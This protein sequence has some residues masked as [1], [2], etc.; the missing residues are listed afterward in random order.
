MRICEARGGSTL[1]IARADGRAALSI[2]SAPRSERPRP[3]AW[4]SSRCRYASART[5]CCPTCAGPARVSACVGISAGPSARSVCVCVVGSTVVGARER[6]HGS[7]AREAHLEHASERALAERLQ[8]AIVL[9]R[10]GRYEWR[11][12][13]GDDARRGEV[14]KSQRI[15][16]FVE[17]P[18]DMRVLAR[19]DPAQNGGD[20][21]H[22]GRRRPPSR[23]DRPAPGCD[24]R[25]RGSPRGGRERIGG[26]SSPD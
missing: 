23:H 13:R 1:R 4:T 8:H 24:E 5:S 6:V 18:A 12:P 11:G 9:H 22:N 15:S 2:A 21:G 26:A 7:P 3:R 10:H 16:L 25:T 17:S 14:G 20:R 19:F